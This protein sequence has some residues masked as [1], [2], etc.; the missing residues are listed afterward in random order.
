[1]SELAS[2]AST[3]SPGSAAP[4]GLP[5]GLW[6]GQLRAIVRLELKKGFLGRRAIWLYLLASAPLAVLIIRWMIPGAVDR[7]NVSSATN[8]LAV[9][10]QIF[11][12]RVILFL[13][14]VGV[15]GNLI[16]REVL[17]RSLHYYFL[18]PVRRQLLV[19]A[20]YLTG[21]TVSFTVFGGA[22]LAAFVLAYLPHDG[23]AV[24]R[25]LFHGP[26][27]SQLFWYLLVTLLACVGYGAV[28]LTFGF[29]FKSPIIPALG[30]LGWEQI[31]FLLPPLLKK[32][33]VIHYLKGLCPVPI[34]DAP[35]AYL[36]DAPSPWVAI[37]GL[38]LLAVVL[39]TLSS[40]R[41]QKMEISYEES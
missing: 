38:L 28:F 21:L 33:S 26:G 7:S 22:T 23:G 40:W 1:V 24:Q 18:A 12:L 8:F 31:N 29:F 15:F 2:T 14:C 37:P 36:A 9:I 32:L 34:P 35:I 16:R 13:S 10:Y 17:D 20:K 6:L 11:L 3:A 30:M 19:A 5:W 39:V 25:F 4:A 41:I 27:L